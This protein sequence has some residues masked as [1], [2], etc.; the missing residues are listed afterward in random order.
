MTNLTATSFIKSGLNL[1]VFDGASFEEINATDP[2]A[3]FVR[4]GGKRMVLEGDYTYDASTGTITGSVTGLAI[5]SQMMVDGEAGRYTVMRLGNLSLGATELINLIK[6]DDADAFFSALM[7]GNDVVRGS[8]WRDLIEGQGGDDR[9]VG[10][11]GNDT[12]IGGA[13]DDTLRGE[14]GRDV[15]N[16]G[17]GADKL[18]GGYADDIL[19][20]GSGADQLLGGRGDDRLDG[21]AGRDLLRGGE[22]ADAFV[23]RVGHGADRIG[24][25]TTDDTLVL[26]DAYWGAALAD[27]EVT[28]A[29]R[30]ALLD[31][32]ATVLEGGILLERGTDRIFIGGITDLDDLANRLRTVAQEFAEIM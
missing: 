14:A 12:L 13:G 6:A 20:G 2:S 18:E 8:K 31:E 16:G 21:G 32:I 24:D 22:G 9:L 17:V 23:F 30:T 10:R 25:F 26:G 3:I 19:T 27:G 5:Q 1:S 7:A 15:L 29:E 11:L 28:L 4:V